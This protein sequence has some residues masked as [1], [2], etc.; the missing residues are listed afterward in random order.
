[1]GGG[2]TGFFLSSYIWVT[3]CTPGLETLQLGPGLIQTPNL[4]V[5]ASILFPVLIWGLKKIWL[6]YGLVPTLPSILPP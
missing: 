3:A 5:P 6:L 1:M 2:E 4:M